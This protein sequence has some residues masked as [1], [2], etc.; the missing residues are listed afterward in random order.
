MFNVLLQILEDGR[1]TDG[2]GRVVNFKNTVIVMTSN[3]GATSIRKQHTLGFGV[4]ADEER[5]Y[6]QMKEQVMEA[7]K[8]TFRPEFLNRLDEIIVF[9]ELNDEEIRQ[10]AGLLLG[11]VAER[12][13][14]RDIRLVVEEDALNLLAE[15]G[16]DP[17]FGARPLRRAIQRMLEDALSEEILAGTIRLG[18][19]IRV[20][21]GD[22]KL[23]FT[24]AAGQEVAVK[25]EAPYGG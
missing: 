13:Q 7:V 8:K 9:R 22:G 23:K 10:I 17:K 6:E 16:Y 21:A 15:A 12:L 24:S 11:K 4:S 25:E 5:G 14:E 20:S 18:E 1:L 19:E 3:A 2:Q